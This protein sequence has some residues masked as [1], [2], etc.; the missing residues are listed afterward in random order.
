MSKICIFHFCRDTFT[1]YEHKKRV[2]VSRVLLLPVLS[3]TTMSV[4]T[5]IPLNIHYE[6]VRLKSDFLMSNYLLLCGYFHFLFSRRFVHEFKQYHQKWLSCQKLKLVFQI[7]NYFLFHIGEELKIA[8]RANP[9]EVSE[10][11]CKN[12]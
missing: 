2:F 4:S 12:M 6:V 10:P 8:Y 1:Y 7:L 9:L 3:H 11:T 5:L